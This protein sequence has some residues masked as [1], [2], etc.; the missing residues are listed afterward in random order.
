VRV[1]VHRRAWTAAQLLAAIEAGRA[2]AIL[3]VR[4]RREFTRGRVPGA[5]HVPFWVLPARMSDVRGSK[6]GPVVVYCGHGPRA[7]FARAVLRWNGFRDVALLEGHMS[8]W[9]REGMRQET[10]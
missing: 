1:S 3:D 6:E 7:W 4:S 10:G 8:R 2:P 5:I 9:V